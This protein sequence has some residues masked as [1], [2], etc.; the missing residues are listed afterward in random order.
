MSCTN[1]LKQLGLG[2]HNYHDKADSLPKGCSIGGG[3]NG[4]T[5]SDTWR[6]SILPYIEQTSLYD[7]VDWTILVA[8]SVNN[9][10]TPKLSRVLVPPYRCPSNNI[11]PFFNYVDPLYPQWPE[12]P[13]EYMLADYVGIAG[14][15]LDPAG[16]NNEVDTAAIGNNGAVVRKFTYGVISRAG[17]LV[18]NEWKGLESCTDG[19]SN[20]FFVGEQSDYMTIAGERWVRTSN[21]N[22]AWLGGAAPD[23][24]GRNKT[25]M[26]YA[27]MAGIYVSGITTA[28]Y[29]INY[30]KKNVLATDDLEGTEGTYSSNTIFNS[31]H[32]GGAHFALWCG[33]V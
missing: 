16:R 31:A 11:P 22:G 17:M 9:A 14:A 8:G 18:Y 7:S 26:D 25:I 2:L 29:S 21:S 6:A 27:A 28:R 33:S 10:N 12:N 32:P 3:S 13:Y 24:N 23:A 19:T 20:T 5:G 30:D 15:Y 4:L 1:N